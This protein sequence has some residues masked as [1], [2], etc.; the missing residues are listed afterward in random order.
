MKRNLRGE[1]LVEVAQEMLNEKPYPEITLEEIAERAGVARTLIFYHYGSREGLFVAAFN[2]HFEQTRSRFV[3]IGNRP[4]NAEER[5]IWLRGEVETF[6]SMAVHQHRLLTSLTVD[7]IAVPEVRALLDDMQEFISGR[8]VWA[9][10]LDQASDLLRG[11]LLAWCRYCVDLCLHGAPSP[12]V[13]N[14]QLCDLMLAHLASALY[15]VA[16]EEAHL[17][18]DSNMISVPGAVLS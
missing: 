8:V 14:R 11:T 16:Q 12:H 7:L 1:R 18:I 10:G 5:W 2:Q 6:I 17:G 15:V 9:L 3:P 13:T 4:T